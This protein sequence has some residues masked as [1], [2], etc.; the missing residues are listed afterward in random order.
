MAT[1]IP[2]VKCFLTV[3]SPS[4]WSMLVYSEE[5]S[6]VP[7]TKPGGRGGSG[8]TLFKK[9]VVSWMYDRDPVIRNIKKWSAYWKV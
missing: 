6:R 2:L 4:S 3:V 9:L 1:I 8:W 5:T 7:N